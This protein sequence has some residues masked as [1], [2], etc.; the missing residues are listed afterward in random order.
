M[1]SSGESWVIGGYP[2][3]NEE[4]ANWKITIFTV[5]SVNQR[6]QWAILLI[7]AHLPGE[8]F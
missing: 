2:Q 5:S 8:G 7:F 3:V 4:F 6:T 1:L